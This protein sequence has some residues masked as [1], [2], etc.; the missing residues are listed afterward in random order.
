[1][2]GVAPVEVVGTQVAIGLPILEHVVEDHQNGMPNGD[3]RAFLAFAA[4]IR[5]NCAA[6]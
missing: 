3:D 6:K 4:A 2:I 5:R 1:L